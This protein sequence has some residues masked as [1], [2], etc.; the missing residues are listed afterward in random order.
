MKIKSLVLLH[1]ESVVYGTEDIFSC[2]CRHLRHA[3]LFSFST[4]TVLDLPL[5]E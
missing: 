4:V 2:G 1:G 3:Y 5:C